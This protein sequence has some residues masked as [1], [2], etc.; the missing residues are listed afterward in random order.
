MAQLKRWLSLQSADVRSRRGSADKRLAASLQEQ[1]GA[2]RRSPAILFRELRGNTGRRLRRRAFAWRVRSSS[3]RP[4]VPKHKMSK[5]QL[6]TVSKGVREEQKT[7]GGPWTSLEEPSVRFRRTSRGEHLN[8]QCR[9]VLG[10]ENVGQQPPEVIMA[11]GAKAWL[12][13]CLVGLSLRRR[14][15]RT[16]VLRTSFS[17]ERCGTQ[18]ASSQRVSEQK[19]RQ[20]TVLRQP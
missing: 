20:V 6:A 7:S 14:Q 17:A 9:P 13:P 15:L 1:D 16:A 10:D 8:L 11:G 12:L 3:R 4:V 19:S 5:K 2:E 18:S